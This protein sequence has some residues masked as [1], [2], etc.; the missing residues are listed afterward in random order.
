MNA[1]KNTPRQHST[2]SEADC[3]A[4][5]IIPFF[6]THQDSNAEWDIHFH[7]SE[8]A[9]LSCYL[10]HTLECSWRRERERYRDKKRQRWGWFKV[11]P[12][13]LGLTWWCERK[14]Q[15]GKN[16]RV[17]EGQKEGGEGNKR[18]EICET[19][20]CSLCCAQTDSNAHQHTLTSARRERNNLQTAVT[21]EK[22][23]L[24]CQ[25]R[26]VAMTTRS[27]ARCVRANVSA[28]SASMQHILM[29]LGAGP[30]VSTS[31]AFEKRSEVYTKFDPKQ[32]AQSADFANEHTLNKQGERVRRDS[33]TNEYN[34]TIT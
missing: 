24:C 13:Q 12:D 8:L 27:P 6:I 22:G 34:P 20:Q 7:W 18:G 14:K 30:L 26:P 10:W 23:S 19:N 4:G 3:V 16:E 5:S 33:F 29:W 31:R 9:E 17:E 2:Q 21:N 28:Q 1:I 11:L 25:S 32:T 15:E